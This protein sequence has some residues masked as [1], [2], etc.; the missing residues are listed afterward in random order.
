MHS[1]GCHIYKFQNADD[2]RATLPMTMLSYAEHYAPKYFL[3]ENV[4]G[5]LTYRLLARPKSHGKA[6]EGG[7]RMGLPK[8]ICRILMSLG[9][10]GCWH[11][12][13]IF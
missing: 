7:V 4:T 2:I 13:T 10:A 5:L 12:L 9:Y 1:A 6:L 11:F 8:L 3:L